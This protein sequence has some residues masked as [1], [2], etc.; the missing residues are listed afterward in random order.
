MKSTAQRA[1]TTPRG[2]DAETLRR[3]LCENGYAHLGRLLS[4]QARHALIAGYERDRLYR[5]RVV[6]QRHAFGR[7]EYRYFSYPLPKQVQMLREQLYRLLVPTANLWQEQ[8]KQT[9]RFPAHHEQFIQRCH[10]AQQTKPTPLLLKYEKDDYNCLHRDLYG[11]TLFPLQVVILLSDPS[12]FSGGEFVLTEQR[13]RM[14]SRASVIP[15]EAGHGVAFAVSDRPRAGKRGYYRVTHRHG[16][17]TVTGGRR[18]ALGVLFHD[19][20]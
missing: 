14:Q 4:V 3:D 17:S 9:L 2:S 5:S 13:P 8:L 1:H 19:A 7:G 15:L 16:V 20:A 6:M 12:E 11:E 10:S 18:H